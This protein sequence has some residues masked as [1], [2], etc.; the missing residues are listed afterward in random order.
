MLEALLA[1]GARTIIVKTVLQSDEFRFFSP[2][3]K[4]HAMKATAAMKAISMKMA[5]TVILGALRQQAARPARPRP[6]LQRC[7]A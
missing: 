1:N 3:K 6:N 5:T 4:S 7:G 2:M